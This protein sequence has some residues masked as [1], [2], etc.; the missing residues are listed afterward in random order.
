[1]HTCTDIATILGDLL[2]LATAAINLAAALKTRPGHHS[3]Q[4]S[5]SNNGRQPK[6]PH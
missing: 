2:T 5:R 3:N 6:K 4:Q 1:M